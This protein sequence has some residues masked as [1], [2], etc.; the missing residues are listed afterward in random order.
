M[1]D[2]SYLCE[3]CGHRSDNPDSCP[4]CQPK[5]EPAPVS[6]A[7]SWEELARAAVVVSDYRPH[8][9]ESWDDD[10]DDDDCRIYADAMATMKRLREQ[11]MENANS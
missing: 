8:P 2:D 9:R 3:K 10:M 5:S 4:K 7:E 11:L 1:S 6:G